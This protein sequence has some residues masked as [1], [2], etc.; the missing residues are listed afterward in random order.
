MSNL[1]NDLSKKT[2]YLETR[3]LV[4]HMTASPLQGQFETLQSEH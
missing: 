3:I 4:H 2:Y 1:K